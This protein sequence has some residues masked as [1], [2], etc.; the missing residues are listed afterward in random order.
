MT[1]QSA[2]PTLTPF[3]AGIAMIFLACLLFYSFGSTKPDLLLAMDNRLLDTMF[4][5]R[6]ARP[7]T[8]SVVIVDIDEQSLQAMG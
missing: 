3:K 4:K 1:R 6:G 7:T 5:W 8:G 2:W